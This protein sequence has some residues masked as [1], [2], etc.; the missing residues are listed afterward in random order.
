MALRKSDLYSSLWKSCD[1]LRGGM[2]ASQYHATGSSFNMVV[3][4]SANNPAAGAYT[5]PLEATQTGSSGSN[6]VWVYRA[7]LLVYIVN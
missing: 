4:L 3:D 1:E 7:N 2:D 6:D 5:L